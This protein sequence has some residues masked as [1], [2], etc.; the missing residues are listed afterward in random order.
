MYSSKV[1]YNASQM[2]ELLQR[3]LNHLPLGTRLWR[4]IAKGGYSD[5][6]K[7][8]Q[9]NLFKVFLTYAPVSVLDK[10]KVNN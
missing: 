7:Y 6:Q 3:R 4:Y 5:Q 1:Y 2:E 8:Q 9:G 10:L